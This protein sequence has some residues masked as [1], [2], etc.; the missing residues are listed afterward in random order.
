MGL[1]ALFLV[2][3]AIC[4]LAPNNQRKLEE[5]EYYPKTIK[6]LQSLKL[7]GGYGSRLNCGWDKENISPDFDV[8]IA[9]YGLR[10]SPAKAIHDSIYTRII[11]FDN[12][13]KKVAMITMDLLIVP[14]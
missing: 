9:G 14:P 5:T 12:G 2:L 7:D 1:L 8:Q 10:W 3:I 6:N 4:L 11:V 13:K